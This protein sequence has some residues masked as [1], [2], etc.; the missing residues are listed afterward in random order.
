MNENKKAME[1]TI[2]YA[3]GRFGTSILAESDRFC[4]I[5]EDL[6]PELTKE[7]EWLAKHYTVQLGKELCEMSQPGSSKT[8]FS[9]QAGKLDPEWNELLQSVAD[10]LAGRKTTTNATQ[11]KQSTGS[12]KVVSA[13][14]GRK[15]AKKNAAGSESAKSTASQQSAGSGAAKTTAS[16]KSAGS[17]AAKSTASQQS[18]GSGAAKSTASQQSAGSGAAK[19]TASQQSAGSTAAKNTASQ[20]SAGEA[21]GREDTIQS[22]RYPSDQTGNAA[23]S[24]AGAGSA[25]QH[26]SGTVRKKKHPIRKFFVFVFILII[27]LF[28][29]PKLLRN[30]GDSSALEDV[31]TEALEGT[32]DGW[33]E[34]DFGNSLEEVSGNCESEVYGDVT[35]VSDMAA[36][37]DGDGDYIACGT[38]INLTENWSFCTYLRCDDVEKEYSAFFAKYET[39]GAGPYA[40]SINNGYVNC[41]FS[42]GEGNHTEIQSEYQLSNGE[43]AMITVV[44]EG[45]VVRLY[46][47]GSLEGEAEVSC[48]TDS[49]DLVTIGR[50]ALMFEP[51]EQLQFTGYI[52]GIFIY[53]DYSLTDEEILEWAAAVGVT[54]DTDDTENEN[55]VSETAIPDG[56]VEYNGHSYYLYDVS[57]LSD[58]STWS[59]AASYCE[60]LG[61]YLACITTADEDAFLYTYITSLGYSSAYFGL[62]ET[63]EDIWAWVSGE[64]VEYTNWGDGEPNN[65]GGSEDYGMYYRDYTSGEWNDGVFSISGYAFLCEWDA[66]GTEVTEET[67]ESEYIL[68][69][70]DSQYYSQSEL[71]A[72]SDEELRLA[73][74]E[75]YARHGRMFDDEELQA[76]FDS[77]SWY[78]GIY[79]P[80]EFDAFGD[81]VF[82]EYELYNRDLIVEVESER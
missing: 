72:L 18:A 71:E 53:E 8:S 57:D 75:I 14:S 13:N 3:V 43:W 66:E 21:G 58:V 78:E 68:P 48:I 37:F 54:T 61:G 9:A 60:S 4:N 51:Y 39:N 62:Y 29:V 52:V 82:N 2:I 69:Y 42:D 17:T 79:T 56:A 41:W 74:N 1:R 20:R 24:G 80:E 25:G 38:G 76:Y 46:V 55:T 6:S 63:S 32:S 59:E 23:A 65:E 47:N 26:T 64:T 44:K 27:V 34:W 16:Q 77:K 5:L 67:E 36:Y 7:Q 45:S 31:I 33:Y 15:T 19:N 10:Q 49:D 22:I 11:Q 50:Q 81:S 35:I 40:F 12:K 70:S 28:V 73:R 30:A